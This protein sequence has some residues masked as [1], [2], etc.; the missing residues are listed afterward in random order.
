[1]RPGEVIID[2]DLEQLLREVTVRPIGDRNDGKGGVPGAELPKKL[3]SLGIESADLDHGE[4]GFLQTGEGPWTPRNGKSTKAGRRECLAITLE[5]VGIPRRYQDGSG[6]F[7]LIVRHQKKAEYDRRTV[8]DDPEERSRTG[9]LP[10]TE[11][12]RIV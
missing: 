11:F 4:A 10:T 9:S 8:R 7:Q 5:S 12:R 3:P 2:A 1:M 6:L